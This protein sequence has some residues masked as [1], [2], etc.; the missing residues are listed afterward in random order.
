MWFQQFITTKL[1][2]SIEVE[3]HLLGDN[4]VKFPTFL[5]FTDKIFAF[6]QNIG[7]VNLLTLH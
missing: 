6:R 5:S 7:R 2:D 4:S 3:E 1:I